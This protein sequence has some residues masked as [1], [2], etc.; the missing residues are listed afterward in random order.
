MI[1]R[2]VKGCQVE[3]RIAEGGT[4]K[5]QKSLKGPEITGTSPPEQREDHE[6]YSAP[7]SGPSELL[8]KRS[9]AGEA[10]PPQSSSLR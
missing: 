1:K 6:K 10:Y 2:I 7:V 4:Q 8:D 5:T 9:E 3:L